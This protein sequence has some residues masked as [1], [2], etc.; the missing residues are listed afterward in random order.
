MVPLPLGGLKKLI[1]SGIIK[2]QDKAI[3]ISTA[4][5]LKFSQFKLDYHS[6]AVNGFSPG[7]TNEIQI[8]KADQNIV[9]E[10]INS[11]LSQS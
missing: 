9:Q 4:H 2:S 1:T 3:V 10:K 7:N 11:F 5:G 8:I 6:N